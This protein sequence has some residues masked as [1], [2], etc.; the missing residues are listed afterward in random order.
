[1]YLNRGW[2][3]PG[4]SWNPNKPVNEAGGYDKIL[5]EAASV[6]MEEFTKRIKMIDEPWLDLV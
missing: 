4:I 6:G 2:K 1:M 3:G 5:R